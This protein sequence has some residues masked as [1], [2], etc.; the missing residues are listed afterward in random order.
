MSTDTYS[1]PSGR[2]PVNIGHL[3][4]G[5]AFLGIL[6]VW[7]LIQADVV[8]GDDV[9]WLSPIPWV[10][11]GIAGLIATA[12][13]GSRRYSLRQAGSAGVASSPAADQPS[14]EV[15]LGDTA[16]GDTA[17]GDTAAETEPSMVADPSAD[18]VAD[19][20]AH[21]ADEPADEPPVELPSGSDAQ[22]GEQ[23]DGPQ[24]LH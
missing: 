10:A 1:R 18:A 12:I 19:T 7:A 15:T 21:A 22:S 16:A 3:V 17:T 5:I 14:H 24:N 8:T 4:M 13:T 11:A 6:G 2:H 20:S 23:S 9:R